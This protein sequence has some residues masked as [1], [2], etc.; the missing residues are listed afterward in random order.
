MEEPKFPRLDQL[1]SAEGT[2]SSHLT[3]DEVI[4]YARGRMDA[5]ELECVDMHVKICPLCASDIDDLREDFL[6]EQLEDVAAAA[7]TPVEDREIRRATWWKVFLPA[8]AGAAMAGVVAMVAISG[9]AKRIDELQR[10]ND[11]AQGDLQAFAR[12]LVPTVVQA[13]PG[14]EGPTP[15]TV[16]ATGDSIVLRWPATSP[17]P[18]H[19]TVRDLAGANPVIVDEEFSGHEY[20]LTFPPTAEPWRRFK[21][22]V[23]QGGREHEGMIYWVA[24]ADETR[25][26]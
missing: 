2:A 4:R 16:L 12:T 15:S 23:V 11:E 14:S 3:E 1:L 19:V 17:G 20:K 5:D 6:K 22:R 26:E 7:A 9:Y 10:R 13:G 18:G 24:A 25:G 21:W 8:L